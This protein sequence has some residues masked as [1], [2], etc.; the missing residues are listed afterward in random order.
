[1][2]CWVEHAAA[3]CYCKHPPEPFA[4]YAA[5]ELCVAEAKHE[6]SSLLIIFSA[7]GEHEHVP[8]GSRYDS[9]SVP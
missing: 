5:D 7:V 9:Y 2:R 4:L 6:M 1:M 8:S 3:S